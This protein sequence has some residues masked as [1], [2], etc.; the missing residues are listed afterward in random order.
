MNQKSYLSVLLFY[1]LEKVLTRSV[2]N[3][4]LGKATA[5]P[6][7]FSFK[8]IG[9]ITNFSCSRRKNKISFPLLFVALFIE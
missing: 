6:P 4:L 3:R 8:K 2:I 7:F 1:F 5:L 9:A